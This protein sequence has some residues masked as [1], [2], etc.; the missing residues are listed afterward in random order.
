LYRRRRR[1]RRRSEFHHPEQASYGYLIIRRGKFIF[2]VWQKQYSNWL[3]P[4]NFLARLCRWRKFVCREVP[5]VRCENLL[6]EIGRMMRNAEICKF[7][8]FISVICSQS[9]CCS[10]CCNRHAHI[11][12][13]AAQKPSAFPFRYTTKPPTRRVIRAVLTI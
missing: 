13:R 10:C 11:S 4:K 7:I 8:I 3:R 2:S 9:S 6:L 1:R 12:C 5:S